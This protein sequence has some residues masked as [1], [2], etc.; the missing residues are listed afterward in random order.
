M[1]LLLVL[2][3]EVVQA[4]QQVVEELQPLLG[5]VVVEQSPQVEEEVE[6]PPQQV[7]VV[8]LPLQ[9]EVVVGL[10]LQGEEVVEPQL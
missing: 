1:E 9:V 6:Q 7:A 10:P 4:Q 5:E 2:L 3:V 8:E